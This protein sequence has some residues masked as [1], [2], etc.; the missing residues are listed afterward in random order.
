MLRVHS[1]ALFLTLFPAVLPAA[2]TRNVILVTADGLRWQDLFHGIDPLLASE[3]SVSMDPS[4]KAADDRR[5]RFAT[6]EDLAPFF[7]RAIARNGIVVSNV[8][9][10]NALRVSYPGYSEILTGRANDDVIKGNDPIQQP[11]ETVLEFLKS[12]LSLSKDRVALFSSWNHFHYIA[13]HT[14]GSIFINAGYQDSPSS[15]ALSQL[16]HV[17]PTPWDEARHDSFTFELAL[18]YLAKHKPRVLAISFDETDDWAHAKRYDRVLD[19]IN[20]TDEFLQ[21]LWTKVQ[22]MPEYRDSTTLIVTS[23]H[24]RGSTLADWSGHGSKVA[25]AD[26]IWMAIMGPDTPHTGEISTHA[27]QRDITPTIIKLMGLNPADYHGANG[28]PIPAAFK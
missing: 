18:E 16:Q 26:K 2:D 15:P 23:D 19:M 9:V 24:G 12:K 21:K 14:P 10:T 27:E 22:S 1:A 13:E 17:T 7:W 11:N 5:R 20:A 6:R 8:N 3:K 25:G 4:S 28:T